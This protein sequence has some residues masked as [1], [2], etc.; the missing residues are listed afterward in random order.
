MC[1]QGKALSATLAKPQPYARVVIPAGGK[2][3]YSVSDGVVVPDHYVFRGYVDQLGL[4][5]TLMNAAGGELDEKLYVLTTDNQNTSSPVSRPLRAITGTFTNS[6]SAPL[7]A[8]LSGWMY[9]V[10]G[11]DYSWSMDISM[12]DATGAPVAQCAPFTAKEV[13]VPNLAEPNACGAQ[14]GAADPINVVQGNFWQTW[15]DLSASGR[16]PGLNWARTYS[17]SEAAIDGPLGFGWTSGYFMSV[18]K[19][20][21]VA[22]VRQE[23]GAAAP[24]ALLNGEWV[25][26]SRV[27][28]TLVEHPD[29]SWTFTRSGRESFTFLPSGQLATVKDLVG[30]ITSLAYSD[31][32][33]STITDAT[34]R[35][36]TVSWTGGR[37]S[38]LALPAASLMTGG[39]S[40]LISVAYTYDAAGDLTTVT[41]AAGGVWT[42]AYDSAHR[43]VSVRE[44]RHHQLGA[45]APILENHYDAAGRVDWQDDRLGRRT[46]FDYAPGATTVTDPAGKVVVHEYN[47]QGVCTALTAN[48]GAAQSRWAYEV[49]MNTLGRTKVT[50]PNGRVVRATY[51]P[52]GRR[53]SLIESGRTTAFTYTETGQPATV[54]DPNRLVTRYGYAAGTDLL[55]S[56]SRPVTPGT[57][58]ATTTLAYG[59]P[60]NPGLVTSATDARGKTTTM[61]YDGS[62]N[63]TTTTDPT[64]NTTSY[65][66][67]ALGWPLS[68]VAPA[69]NAAGGSASQHTTSYRYNPRGEV[70]AVTDPLGA[71]TE[72]DRDASGNVT[73]LREPV[74]SGLKQTAFMLDAAS[75]VTGVTRPGGST[76]LTAFWPDGQLKSQTDAAGNT[77]NYGYDAQGRLA[78]TTDPAGRTTSYGYDP[79]GRPVTVQQPAGNCAATPRTGCIS[80]AY[81]AAGDVSLIDYS[82]PATPDVSYTYDTLH[83]RIGMTDGTGSSSWTWDSLDRIR[84]A[85][86]VTGTITYGYTDNGPGATST[87]YP[88]NKTV[89][90]T[91]DDA[92]RQISTTGWTGGTAN[93]NYDPNSNLSSTDTPATTGV[94]DSY[95]YDQANRM[96][97]ATLR[98][99]ASTLTAQGWT[100]DPRGQVTTSTGLGVPAAADSFTYSPLDQLSSSTA[101]TYG[102]DSADNLNALANGTKQKFDPANQLCYAASTNTAACGAAPT[103]ATRFDYDNRGNRTTTRPSGRVPTLLSYDQA[104]RLTQAKVPTAPDGS[105][106]YHDLSSTA[107]YLA[108]NSPM[109][110]NQT[111]DMQ[112]TGTN[113]IPASGVE[114]VVLRL[115]AASPSSLGVL[116]VYPTGTSPGSTAAM[117]YNAGENASN[118]AISKVNASGS[119]SL[120]NLAGAAAVSVELLGWYGN[121]DASGGLTFQPVNP[122][123][124]FAGSIAAGSTT[125]IQISGQYGVP[126]TGVAAV[127]VVAHS[128][129]TAGSGAGYLNV[130]SGTTMPA[131]ATLLY[132]GGAGSALATVALGNDGTL[133]LA[134][135]ATTTAALDI[136]GYFTSVESGEGN[137]AHT[138]DRTFIANTVT[139]TGTCNASTCNRLL[140]N[141][142]TTIKVTG[143]GGIPTN[144]AAVAVILETYNPDLIGSLTTYATG[145]A[146]PNAA[147]M[148]YD[149]AYTSSTAIIPV[150]SDGT[151]TVNSTRGVDLVIQ[152][153]GYYDAASKTYTYNYNGDGLRTRKTSADGTITTFTW[154]RTA[155]L[156]QLLTENIDAPGTTNDRTV[157]Y[158]YAPD[159]TVTADITTS[160]GIADTIRYHHHDQLGSTRSLINATGATL[161]TFAYDPFGTATAVN[162]TATTPIGWA[163]QYRDDETGYTYL[164]ARYYDPTSGQFLTRD[165][166]VAQTRSAYGYVSNNPTNAV[167]P[168]GLCPFCFVALGAALL[169]GGADLGY[170]AASNLIAGCEP[171]NNIRWGSVAINAAVGGLVPGL[172]I[173]HASRNL[174]RAASSADEFVD[175]ASASRR[176]H[177]LAGDRTGGGHLWPGLPGK[178]PFPRSWSADRIMHEIADVATDPRSIVTAGRGGSTIITGTRGG[179]RLRVILR[180]GEIV[181]GYP[182]NLARNMQ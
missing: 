77:T 28:A 126:T 157:R 61:T 113:G 87:I 91:Y 162:G 5:A 173:L 136:V 86:D 165:P 55:V 143:V 175:L 73:T 45:S 144:A 161:A 169:G 112:I 110:P 97:A 101:G 82:D 171:L 27:D 20:G 70:L 24:F 182:T 109:A 174:A 172:S 137:I 178:T 118:M 148:L 96:T 163:G 60:S 21:G 140:A 15:S 72:T 67:N 85:T 84:S 25:A 32:Q 83:R 23:S 49:D 151:I 6:S 80:Y 33:L 121:N 2:L 107:I 133:K 69:G 146:A 130:Y 132:E 16:G 98:Q 51:D 153:L 155:G 37:V 138:L 44:P 38:A 62:G 46:T 160:N 54:T 42:F 158:L 141:T 102:Y 71:V 94:E 170:Q 10:N 128:N 11:L 59:D 149:D 115:H 159:G 36:M 145:S 34:G 92:G 56:T 90:R 7:S 18:S 78:S 108:Y 3:T 52:K 26:P 100:R 68:V 63:L 177:I 35:T 123:R 131:S 116:C 99:G 31:G 65:S 66:H 1:G 75:Q 13:A 164:R 104:D 125:P 139:H 76:L 111:L 39:P 79:A 168:S 30:N 17:S 53:T 181:T 47:A 22:T 176:T 93:Y 180:D 150:G 58:T 40:T 124:A 134:T 114:S 29:G 156:P 105:G 117:Y 9:L 12:T 166:L 57:G 129:A 179:V 152:T 41:D 103:G 89:S 119:V 19:I 142:P 127:A 8:W 122:A 120:Q 167:D 147:S 154:D 88:G 14:P 106:Q 43:I 48:P 74:V 64:G 135:S 81:N 50:D 4:Y 95:D